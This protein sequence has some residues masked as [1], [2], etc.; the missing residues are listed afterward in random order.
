MAILWDYDGTLAD[1]SRK[2]MEVTISIFRKFYP[3]IAANMPDVLK[4]YDKYQKANHKYRNW[5]E[6]YRECYGIEEEELDRAGRL[7]AEGQL[8]DTA[9]PDIFPGMTEL[10]ADL[11]G[12]PMGICSQNSCRNIEKTLERYGI[13]DCFDAIVGYDSI[14]GK[15]QKPHPQGFIMCAEKLAETDEDG[16]LIYIGDHRDDITFARGAE[17][18]LGRKVICITIDHLKYNGEN[19]CLWDEK[20][21]YY[22]TDADGLRKALKEICIKR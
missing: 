7:W 11:R 17:R 3:D 8:K 19:F 6:L 22:V 14:S 20:P 9:V 13:R 21:D 10:L 12:I 2:N 1:S 16:R 15:F 18:L 5:R 4:S